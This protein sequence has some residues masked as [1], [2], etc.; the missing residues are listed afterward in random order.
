MHVQVTS[1]KSVAKLSSNLTDRCCI[2]GGVLEAT[3]AN[4]D[5]GVWFAHA[6]V[7]LV[8]GMATWLQTV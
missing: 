5:G 7:F 3:A 1:R 6:L 4:S 2:I 8:N